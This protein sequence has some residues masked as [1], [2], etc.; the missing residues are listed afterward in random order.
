[1]KAPNTKPAGVS[2]ASAPKSILQVAPFKPA[3]HT[4][5]QAAA[6]QAVPSTA[7]RK[8]RAS[9]ASK[10]TNPPTVA[11]GELSTP[12][13]SSVANAVEKPLANGV[14]LR[15]LA[16]VARDVCVVGTFNDWQIGATPLKSSSGGEWRAEL[17]LAPGRYEYLFVVDGDWTPD[18]AAGKAVQNP[19]GGVNSVFLVA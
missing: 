5:A 8:P 14:A 13:V 4:L 19:F 3:A 15:L 9:R 11:N 17:K 18:P 12:N 6:P 7:P 16:P 2:L 1:M 10:P